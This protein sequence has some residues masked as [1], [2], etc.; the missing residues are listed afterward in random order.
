MGWRVG[1]ELMK[2]G[3]SK[4]TPIAERKKLPNKNPA[5]ISRIEKT[6]RPL[7]VVFPRSQAV[8]VDIK[9]CTSLNCASHSS[10]MSRRP[11]IPQMDLQTQ[12]E[13]VGRGGFG[14]PIHSEGVLIK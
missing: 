10:A 7:C 9:R 6:S 3:M 11:S 2:A 5:T 13:V 12:V 14:P 1:P 8:V 4:K